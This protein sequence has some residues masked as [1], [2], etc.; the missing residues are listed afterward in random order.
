MASS[1]RD[2]VLVKL[3]ENAAILESEKDM[4]K[5]DE[6]VSLLVKCVD[7]L[8]KLEPSQRT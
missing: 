7:L 5:Q 1:L 2:L 4:K 6:I 3:K 8:N